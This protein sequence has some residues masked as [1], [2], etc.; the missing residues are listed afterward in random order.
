MIL[1]GS[2]DEAQ[3]RHHLAL[4]HGMLPRWNEEADLYRGAARGRIRASYGLLDEADRSREAIREA[5]ALADTLCDNL[6]P[7]HELLGEL[8]RVSSTLE[9]LSTSIAIS[10]EQMAPKIEADQEV[11]GLRYLV[12]ALKSH[13][14]L[15][16]RAS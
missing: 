7:G 11:A 9:A 4:W 10:C 13:S 8:F 16:G 5:L 14:G 1:R 15:G 3:A 6:M 2:N 12:S